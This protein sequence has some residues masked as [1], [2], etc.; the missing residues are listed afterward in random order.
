MAL[1]DRMK[2]NW[3][4]LTLQEKKAGEYTRPEPQHSIV[5]SAGTTQAHLEG[6]RRASDGFCGASRAQLAPACRA[7][8]SDAVRKCPS[9]RTLTQM[10]HSL[11]DCFRPSRPTCAASRRREQEGHTLCPRR[12]RCLPD[13][14]RYH[15]HVRQARTTHHDAR[16]AGGFQRVPQG[17]S[18]LS[19]PHWYIS[20]TDLVHQ[21]YRSKKPTLSPVSPRPTTRA[22]DR[23]S[24]RPRRLKTLRQRI[25]KVFSFVGRRGRSKSSRN[26]IIIASW[27]HLHVQNDV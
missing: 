22:K 11:L 19:P 7:R 21:K 12:P 9:P 10:P 3:A 26:N 6:H 14:L 13:H 15:A 18:N 27:P 25:E 5:A 4:D 20:R 1:R 23:S 17:P 2:E 24:R 8:V 16:V